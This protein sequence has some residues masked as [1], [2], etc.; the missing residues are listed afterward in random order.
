MKFKKKIRKIGTSYGI[1]LPMWLIITRGLD[2][3]DIIE[4]DSD[5]IDNVE[6]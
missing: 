4:I 1:I 3:G 5:D 2:L 6:K